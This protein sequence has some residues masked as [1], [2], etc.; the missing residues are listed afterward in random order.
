MEDTRSRDFPENI[1]G[2]SRQAFRELHACGTIEGPF[3]VEKI[4]T[5]E[6]AP[7]HIPLRQADRVIPHR[8]QHAPVNLSLC[9]G[10]GGTGGA[11]P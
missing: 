11:M 6:D 4:G 10:V 9:F 3:R 7:Y 8:I 2:V 1:T 5:V